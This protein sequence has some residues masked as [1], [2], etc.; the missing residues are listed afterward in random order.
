MPVQKAANVGQ[1]ALQ[2]TRP[3]DGRTS[4]SETPEEKERKST[5]V[6]KGGAGPGGEQQTGPIDKR[7]RRLISAGGLR[8]DVLASQDTQRRSAKLQTAV[9]RDPGAALDAAT[10][11]LTR[12]AMRLIKGVG[13]SKAED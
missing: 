8:P 10:R 7:F 2:R 3:T 5:I 9:R 1:G 6:K 4:R 12:D 11:N 13:G